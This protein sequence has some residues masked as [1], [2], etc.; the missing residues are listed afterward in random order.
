MSYYYETPVGTAEIIFFDGRWH[1]IFAGKRLGTHHCPVIAAEQISTATV[2]IGTHQIDL[3][4][5]NIPMDLAQWS[6]TTVHLP[7]WETHQP[8]PQQQPQHLHQAH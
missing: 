5:L 4:K 7:H 3:F 8:I 1:T 2:D 6:R